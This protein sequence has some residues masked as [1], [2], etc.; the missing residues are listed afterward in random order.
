M[1][2]AAQ[3]LRLGMMSQAAWPD[4]AFAASTTVSVMAFLA[5]SVMAI[6]PA[7]GVQSL[8]DSH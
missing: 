5:A 8:A 4:P 6:C 7:A 3:P 1:I 2:A